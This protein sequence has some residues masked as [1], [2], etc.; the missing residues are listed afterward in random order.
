MGLKLTCLIRTFSRPEILNG[1]CMSEL[2]I[3]F[4]KN[5]DV[6]PRLIESLYLMLLVK[7][8]NIMS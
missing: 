1:R 2:P 5:R 6:H 7:K 4:Y 8:K 3:K